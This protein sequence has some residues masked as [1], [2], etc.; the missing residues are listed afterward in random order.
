MGTVLFPGLSW[1]CDLEW[2][3]D[4]VSKPALI[5]MTRNVIF[6]MGCLVDGKGSAVASRNVALQYVCEQSMN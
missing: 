6:L 1:G 2:L 3:I 4:T 5:H